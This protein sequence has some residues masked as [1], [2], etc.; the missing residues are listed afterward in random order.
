MSK[1]NKARKNTLQLSGEL[2]SLLGI[3]V[4]ISMLLQLWLGMSDI[5]SNVKSTFTTLFWILLAY[6]IFLYVLNFFTFKN[7]NEVLIFLYK[8]LILLL[9]VMMISLISI[10]IYMNYL[11]KNISFD[12]IWFIVNMVLLGVIA[13]FSSYILLFQV[14][15]KSKISLKNKND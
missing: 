5:T 6:F 3:A 1:K 4:S 14:E 11:D 7:D 8:F 2:I 10:M 15:K 13:L 12:I 9:L